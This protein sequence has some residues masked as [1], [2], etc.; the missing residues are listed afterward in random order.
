MLSIEKN[1]REAKTWL[2]YAKLNDVLFK[3]L[4]EEKSALNC[5]KGYFCA[6]TLN[7]HKA[8]LIIPHVFKLLKQKSILDAAQLR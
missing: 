7:Q 3:N 2:A 5:L 8:R 4:E 1:K 6:M